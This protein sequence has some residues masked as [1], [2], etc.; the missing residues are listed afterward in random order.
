MESETGR[1]WECY[2]EESE[3]ENVREQASGDGLIAAE[4]ALWCFKVP[5]G[6]VRCLR[7]GRLCYLC[8]IDRSLFDVLDNIAGHRISLP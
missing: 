7:V 2:P 4:G 3:E 5:E 1:D 6:S 8:V